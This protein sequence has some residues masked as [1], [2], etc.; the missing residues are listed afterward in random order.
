MGKLFE[1]VGKVRMLQEVAESAKRW[2]ASPFLGRN[3]AG[4]LM[5]KFYI[6]GGWKRPRSTVVS[7]SLIRYMK[8]MNWRIFISALPRT[9]MSDAGMDGFHRANP[10]HH[11][12]RAERIET[13]DLS[14]MWIGF[15]PSMVDACPLAILLLQIRLRLTV[16]WIG[17]NVTWK[18]ETQVAKV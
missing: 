8:Q 5:G 6:Y 10:L 16:F 4:G 15:H 9:E 17:W 13:I 2:Q 11:D 7:T 14:K 18:V 12:I 3:L 1:P